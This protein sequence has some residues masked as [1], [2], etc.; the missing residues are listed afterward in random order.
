GYDAAVNRY[1]RVNS[2]LVYLFYLCRLDYANYNFGYLWKNIQ[3]AG[4]GDRLRCARLYLR[5]LMGSTQNKGKWFNQI[6]FG[7]PGAENPLGD[8]AMALSANYDKVFA[9]KD[10]R[11][12]RARNL[13]EAPAAAQAPAQA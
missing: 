8:A 5:Y 10:A 6:L 9:K 12:P 13:V 7:N 11:P 4:W 2:M 3:W 1:Y